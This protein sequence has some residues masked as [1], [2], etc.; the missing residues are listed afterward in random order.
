[1]DPMANV[2]AQGDSV[3]IGSL[4]IMLPGI[5][6]NREGITFLVSVVEE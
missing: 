6:G 5:L 1:M 4:V 2:V 3:G